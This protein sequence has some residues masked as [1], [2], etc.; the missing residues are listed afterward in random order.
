MWKSI[1]STKVNLKKLGQTQSQQNEDR[2]GH[3]QEKDVVQYMTKNIFLLIYF[4]N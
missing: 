2:H 3:D 4:N 1:L